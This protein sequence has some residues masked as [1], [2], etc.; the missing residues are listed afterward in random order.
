MSV[1][2]AA[3]TSVVGVVANEYG[4]TIVPMHPVR[5]RGAI[6]PI[7]AH[8]ASDVELEVFC[9]AVLEAWML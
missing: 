6:A 8:R 3:L 1:M 5:L 9:I 7:K 2:A 4:A